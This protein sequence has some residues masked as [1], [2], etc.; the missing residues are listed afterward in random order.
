MN[1]TN[2]T[3]LEKQHIR[4][5]N[6]D[7]NSVCNAACP[8]C[9]RQI[10]NIYPSNGYPIN[11]HMSTE[12]WT[13]LFTEMGPIIESVVLCGN[14]GDAAGTATLPELIELAHTINPKIHFIVVS[15]M[16]LGSTAFWKKLA[17]LP[18]VMIQ[19][20]I[21]GL[22]DT[23]HIYR[24][25]VDWSI[26]WRNINTITQHGAVCEWKFI[27]FSWNTHQIEEARS[28]SKTLGFN[29]FIVT[30]NNNLVA[31]DIF[32]KAYTDNID[33]WDNK[34]AFKGLVAPEQTDLRE[35]D[36]FDVQLDLLKS[37]EMHADTIQCYTKTV[38]QSIHIDWQGS[39]WPC[40]WYGGAVYHPY[41]LQRHVHNST[42]AHY[43][44]DWNNLEHH[45]VGDTPPHEFYTH[46]L[47]VA[48]DAKRSLTCY[49]SC[50]K[51]NDEFNIVN[52]I[53]KQ[54]S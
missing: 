37:R 27:E 32:Y 39:V 1:L 28:I 44:K 31:N 18:N 11:K 52:T 54:S 45:T 20:S 15:N 26:V 17:L 8:G 14:Y 3:Y 34:R 5:L 9:A 2:T 10:D 47:M 12:T 43:T 36:S 23:N 24:R 25:F 29:N 33:D 22:S 19:C 13:K 6:I 42:M 16:G 50:G 41:E 40:C 30:P 21:D 49:A 38:D 53:G 48:Q 51:C 35:D 7:I 46:D 4:N